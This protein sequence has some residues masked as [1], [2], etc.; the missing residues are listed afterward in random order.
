MTKTALPPSHDWTTMMDAMAS[1]GAPK[2]LDGDGHR[3]THAIL[4]EVRGIVEED[5]ADR[6]RIIGWAHVTCWVDD[7]LGYGVA[8]IG[9][10]GL[11][12][13]EILNRT[14]LWPIPGAPAPRLLDEEGRLKL[15]AMDLS[16]A[17]AR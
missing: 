9:T 6:I 12:S 14:D 17:G 7:S 8:R 3:P 4:G 1:C 11:P 2:A 10:G 15:E 5:L 13:W 16:P